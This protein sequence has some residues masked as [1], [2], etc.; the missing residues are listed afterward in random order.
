MGRLRTS[1][2]VAATAGALVTISLAGAPSA[3]AATRKAVPNTAST[4]VLKAH[5]L[6]RAKAST[7]TTFKVYLAPRGGTDALKAAVAKVSDPKSASYRDH[8]TA[9]QYHAAYDATSASVDQVSDWLS[10]NKLKVTEVEAHHRYLTVNGSVASVQRAFGVSINTYQHNGVTVRAN[11]KAV[12]VPA[13][14]AGTISG[15]SGLDTTPRK[16]QHNATPAEPP[17]PGF[18][19]ARPCSTY[20]G[21]VAAKYQSDFKTK[22]PSFAGKTLPYSVCGYTGPQL[23]AAYEN[24]STL[25]GKGVTVAITDAYASPTIRRDVT[26]Y[27]DRHGDGRYTMGQYTE[28]LPKA[29]TQQAECEPQGWYGEQT[30]DVEAVHAMATGANIRYYASAS[31]FDSD[32][33]DTLGRVVDENK[34][35][36][37]SNSWS[38]LEA[39]ESVDN[40]VA[41]E[42]VFLQG[43][44]QGIGFMFSSGDYGDELAKTGLKQVDYP[45]SDPY[46]TAVGGTSDAIGADG[47]FLWQG[48][49]GTVKYN[50]STDGKSWVKQGFTSGAGGGYSSLFERPSYQDGVVPSRFGPGRAVPD[51]GLTAD[52]T[53][54]FL[55]GQTQT[56]PDGPNYGEYRLG[57]TSLASP[58]YAGMAALLNQHVGG[59]V[60]FLNPTIYSQTKKGVFHDVLGTPPQAG[61]VRP[62]YANGVDKTDGILYSVRLFDLDSSLTTITG[63]DN[64]TGVG[65][66]NYKWLTS[67]SKS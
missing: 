61:N 27:V 33:L 20:Y 65:S 50:L 19:N 53:T 56:F 32:F 26:S 55:V 2:A 35:S 25:T 16:I 66:P 51:V 8:L 37:V 24:N 63:W 10:S 7:A 6:G 64:V 42:Q 43:A 17:A 59:R 60:G 18:R 62:D 36:I 29:F 9:A 48:G 58:L 11:N 5:S 12:T 21:Q 39:N 67:V 52:P 49:W 34:A 3:D 22:L 15:V 30:L 31:C 57:G 1:L 40:V 41:Y 45:S 44:L 54:G 23:R 28:V 38:D 47:K 14:L 4:W 46:V 13:S